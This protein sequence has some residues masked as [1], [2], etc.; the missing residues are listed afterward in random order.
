MFSKWQ[1]VPHPPQPNADFPSRTRHWA[2]GA[3]RFPLA[4]LCLMAGP[5]IAAAAGEP[6]F[7]RGPGLYFNLFKLL[8]FLLSYFCWI[9]ICGWI[10]YDARKVKLSPPMWNSVMLLCALAGLAVVWLLPLFW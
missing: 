5:G 7:P 1:I 3:S 4:V 2:P 10:D 9:P 6:I 8:P